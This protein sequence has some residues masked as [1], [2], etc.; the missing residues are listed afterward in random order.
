MTMRTCCRIALAL[1]LVACHETPRERMLSP[2]SGADRT[3]ASL[4]VHRETPGDSTALV[5]V[6]L[7]AGREVGMLGSVTAAVAFDTVALRFMGEES[8]GGPALRALHA[9]GGRVRV[10]AAAAGGLDTVVAGMRFRV[11]D[12]AAL[13]TLGLQ[14]SELHTL[15]AADARASLVM[16]PV[17][18]AP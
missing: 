4:V 1:L 8:P 17:V 10:A 12:P 15:D 18:I 9:Q 14:V 6:R 2:A 16:A 11:V 5:L 13:R 7:V 3:L